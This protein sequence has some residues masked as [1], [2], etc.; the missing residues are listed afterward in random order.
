MPSIQFYFDFI[1]PF[2][3]IASLQIDELARRS[4]YTV[5]W[6][7]MLLGVSVLK[8]MGLKPLLDTPLKGDYLRRQM[9]RHRR[10]EGLALKRSAD[11]PMMDPR[12]CARAY[13]WTAR[14]AAPL[15]KPL[16]KHL[17]DRYWRDGEDLTS[18]RQI[19]DGAL[20]AG[21]DP[22]VLAEGMET[23]EARAMLRSAVEDSLKRGVFGSPTVVAGDELQKWADCRLQIV[24]GAAGEEIETAAI[25]PKSHDPAATKVQVAAVAPA[26]VAEAKIANRRIDPAIDSQ[27]QAIGRVIGGAVGKAKPEIA[28]E[29]GLFVGGAVA[30]GVAKRRNMG[31]VE[32]NQPIVHPHQ[33]TGTIHIGD[34]LF[35]V[36]SRAVPIGIA[37]PENPAAMWFAVERAIAVA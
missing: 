23:A 15:A 30:I 20:P 5:E 32:H 26:G 17:L 10:R 14:H 2:G 4:G 11:D 36:V 12:A 22:L 6:Y 7:P 18:A 1:S 8:V 21:L 27:C 16:A 3:Y 24:A 37:Q 25:G 31:R 28:H 9:S 19:V 33:P 29:P 34:K 35:H 13:Y